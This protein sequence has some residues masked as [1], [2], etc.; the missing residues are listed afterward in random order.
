MNWKG[1]WSLK[2]GKIKRSAHVRSGWRP[3]APG[4]PCVL[5]TD[6]KGVGSLFCINYPKWFRELVTKGDLSNIVVKS[7]LGLLQLL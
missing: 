5:T 4:D 1:G 6:E 7:S 2:K 3:Q